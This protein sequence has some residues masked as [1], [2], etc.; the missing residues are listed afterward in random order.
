MEPM[1]VKSK[2]SKEMSLVLLRCPNGHE[3][4]GVKECT[5]MACLGKMKPVK[6]IRL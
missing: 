2:E 4:I 1:D 6:A 5:C 3:M